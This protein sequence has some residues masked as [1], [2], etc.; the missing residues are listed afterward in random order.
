MKALMKLIIKNTKKD[1]GYGE[2][3]IRIFEVDLT[4]KDQ[5]MMILQMI[6]TED[7]ILEEN[8]DIVW[9]FD[10]ELPPKIKEKKLVLVVAKDRNE[11]LG[12][13]L[14][15]GLNPRN[16]S[17]VMFVNDLDKI[18]GIRGAEVVYYGLWHQN[19]IWN[20]ADAMFWLKEA[21]RELI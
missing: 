18:R 5:T 21:Q 17:Q 1:W 8:V 10:E 2:G 14:I 4:E 3:V 16:P 9:S 15:W 20:Y 11:F 13:C 6:D 7:K 19:D 12:Y